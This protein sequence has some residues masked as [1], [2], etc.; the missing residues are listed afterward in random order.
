MRLL[1]KLAWRNIW[2]NKRRTIITMS[3]IIL[4]M[5]LSIIMRSMQLGTYDKMINDVVGTYSGYLQIH[6]NGYW[7]DKTLNNSFHFSDDLEN[8]I[9][10]IDGVEGFVPRVESF[11]LAAGDEKSR[12]AFVVGIDPVKENA[13]TNLQ[14]KIVSGKYFETKQKGALITEGLASF[15]NLT[16]G[17]SIILLG[18]GYHGMNAAGAFPIA[19]IL[20][21][22]SPDM[23]KSFVYVDVKTA[24]NLFSLDN[25][26]TSVVVN[27]GKSSD[28]EKIKGDNAGGIIMLGILYMIVA[29]GIFGTILMMTSERIREFGMNNALGL[30]RGK[31]GIMVTCET[32]LLGFLSLVVGTI[33]SLPIVLYFH[34][35]PIALTG[36]AAKG[37]INFGVEPVLPFLLDP[38]IFVMQAI[39]VL[40]MAILSTIYPL[41][42]LK[43]LNPVSAMHK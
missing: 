31:L 30:T 33:I 25:L 29:F 10:G 13:L 38:G 11:A 8:T 41:I 36:E 32:T 37:M 35:N 2:R 3:S 43:T 14:S 15:L 40:S 1:I 18:Q 23:N 26:L 20:K 39:I 16:I 12:G 24:Q 7:D 17:D 34:D 5:V 42:K 27:I 21:F 6:A 22:A 19:G 28:V 4:A 9:G